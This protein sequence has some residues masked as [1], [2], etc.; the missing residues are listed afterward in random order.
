M[1]DVYFVLLSL[2]LKTENNTYSEHKLKHTCSVK[3]MR[4]NIFN[5]AQL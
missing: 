2:Y 1:Y 5:A 4:V 3:V